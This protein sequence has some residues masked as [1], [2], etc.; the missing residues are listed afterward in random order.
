MNGSASFQLQNV[1]LQFGQRSIFQDFSLNISAGSFVTLLGP[2]GSGKSTLLRLLTNWLS[3][4]SGQIQRTPEKPRYG[5]VFQEASLLDWRTVEENLQLPFELLDV[6]KTESQEQIV[7]ELA[8][9]RLQEFANYFPHQLSG[10]MKMRTSLARALVTKPQ[11]LLMDEPFSALDEPTR[12]GL[13]EDLRKI[14]LENKPTILFVTHSVAEAVFLSDRVIIL[15]S[16]G[17]M[18]DDCPIDLGPQR[19]APLRFDPKY[20]QILESISKKIEKPL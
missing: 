19:S 17:K 12:F 18:I 5:F 3:P 14:W 9:V 6:S 20:L 8:R 10:G 4:R 2:S 15:S 16:K 1:S 13:Q 7:R 11:V